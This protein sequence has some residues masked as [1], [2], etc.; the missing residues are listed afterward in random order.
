MLKKHRFCGVIASLLG[1]KN[2]TPSKHSGPSGRAWAW[3]ARERQSAACPVVQA[4]AK[5][6]A[7]ASCPPAHSQS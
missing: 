6:L 5:R 1:C 4:A 3:A 7:G 2:R